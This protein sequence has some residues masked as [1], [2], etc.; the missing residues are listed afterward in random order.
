MDGPRSAAP[1]PRPKPGL[2]LQFIASS[3]GYVGVPACGRQRATQSEQGT[4]TGAPREGCNLAGTLLRV[5]E[6][7]ICGVEIPGVR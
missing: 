1:S 7:A 2:P 3:G 5:R 6:P 4:G